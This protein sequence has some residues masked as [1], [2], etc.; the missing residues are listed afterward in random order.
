MTEWMFWTGLGVTALDVLIGLGVAS[1]TFGGTVRP[2]A[3]LLDALDD[4]RASGALTEGG[5]RSARQRIV[6]EL[7]CASVMRHASPRI[8]VSSPCVS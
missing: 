1:S 6:D 4:L 5:Y 2:V 8:V 7:L 3:E